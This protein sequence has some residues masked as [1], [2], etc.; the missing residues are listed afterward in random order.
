MAAA[1]A[2]AALG[3]EVVA[4]DSGSRPLPSLPDGVTAHLRSDGLALLDRARAV[5]KSP[6]VPREAAVIAAARARGIPVLGVAVAPVNLGVEVSAAA[7]GA[8]RSVPVASSTTA[9]AGCGGTR[10][11]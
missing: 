2:L 7:R 1:R 8:C 5:V 6:G 3:E 11:P 4:V 10:R 9:P